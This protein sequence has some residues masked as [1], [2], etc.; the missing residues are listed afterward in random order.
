[1]WLHGTSHAKPFEDS[2]STNNI[3][4]TVIGWHVRV[5]ILAGLV[6]TEV[7]DVTSLTAVRM[8]IL[9]Q[10]SWDCVKT[11]LDMKQYNR[12]VISR[13][14][15]WHLLCILTL[16]KH[17][18]MQRITLF[19]MLLFCCSPVEIHDV[20]WGIKDMCTLIDYTCTVELC[21][22]ILV[23]FYKYLF[24]KN[25]YWQLPY[26]FNVCWCRFVC[27]G[28]VVFHLFLWTWYKCMNA[29]V[30]L[31][32]SCMQLAPVAPFPSIRGTARQF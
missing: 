15:A 6:V 31:W 7:Q 26:W 3:L 11:H 12:D 21:H 27:G 16:W 29:I 25:N 19:W 14:D 18:I 28:H 23:S 2:L 24:S 17:H 8:L 30:S 9:N 10:D 20:A 5:R 4:F 22:V 32:H 1:M 13:I